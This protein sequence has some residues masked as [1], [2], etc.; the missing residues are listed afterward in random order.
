MV[1]EIKI[2]QKV[3]HSEVSSPPYYSLFSPQSSSGNHFVSCGFLKMQ[4]QQNIKVYSY[5]P[6]FT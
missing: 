5:H 6:P 3:I 4:L 1:D 2:I